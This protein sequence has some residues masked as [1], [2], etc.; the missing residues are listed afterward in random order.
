MSSFLSRLFFW[1]SLVLKCVFAME[2]SVRFQPGTPI[3]ERPFLSPE[4]AAHSGIF[5]EEP[6]SD[7]PSP[8]GRSPFGNDSA[9]F[10]PYMEA[11]YGGLGPCVGFNPPCLFFLF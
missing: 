5:Y 4:M 3:A 7:G 1:F 9:Q 10:S 8:Y 6:A 11:S 2:R